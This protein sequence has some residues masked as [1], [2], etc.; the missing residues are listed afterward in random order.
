MDDSIVLETPSWVVREILTHE[1]SDRHC[2]HCGWCTR[3]K[4]DFDSYIREG[5]IF[6]FRR[7]GKRRASYQLFISTHG[8]SEFKSKGN[9]YADIWKFQED[10]YELTAWIKERVKS[11]DEQA[12]SFHSG[13]PMMVTSEDVRSIAFQYFAANSQTASVRLTINESLACTFRGQIDGIEEI[14][15]EEF[16]AGDCF[17]NRRDRGVYINNGSGW[18]ITTFEPEPCDLLPEDQKPNTKTN[19]GPLHNGRLVNGLRRKLRSKW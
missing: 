12:R 17:Y 4:M 13:R 11:S 2:R 18:E 10:E 7:R 9:Q 3:H 8:I 6:V 19:S 15:I 1:A 14:D 5:K 16:P